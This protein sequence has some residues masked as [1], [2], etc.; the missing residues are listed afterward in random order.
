MHFVCQH[1]GVFDYNRNFVHFLYQGFKHLTEHKRNFMHLAYDNVSTKF[2]GSRTSNSYN[3]VTS[4]SL[5]M[6]GGVQLPLKRL[7]RWHQ[8]DCP[9]IRSSVVDEYAYSSPSSV[10]VGSLVS[11]DLGKT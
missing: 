6:S 8:N 5:I 9:C 4:D 2:A 3:S 1:L 7:D 10:S 11:F